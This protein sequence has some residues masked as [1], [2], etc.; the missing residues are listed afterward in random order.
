MKG[1][2]FFNISIPVNFL[3]EGNSFVAYTPVLDL[4]TSA[5]TYEKAQKRFSEVVQI[6]FEELVEMGTLDE[7]L[8]S[9]GWEK[10]DNH[11]NP[12]LPISH[13]VENI[14]IPLPS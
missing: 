4:S 14:S 6:F 13:Q 2:V 8:S 12:P 7:V 10:M 9:L 3:K 5:D 1:K 11:W